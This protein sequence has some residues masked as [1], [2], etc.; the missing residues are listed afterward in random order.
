MPKVTIISP[1]YN[2]APYIKGCLK[3]VFEQTFQ[4]FELLLVDDHGQD[5]SM[6]VAREYVDEQK[7]TGRVFFL[8]TAENSGAGVARNV[9]LEAAKGKFIAF[10][11]SDDEWKPDFLE[12]LVHAA[13]K[14]GDTDLT[15]CQL[16]YSNGKVYRNPVVPSGVFSSKV[17]QL[18]LL[19]FVTFSVCFLFRRDFLTDNA[20]KFPRLRNS[21]D[22]H[23]LTSCLLLA[24]S[25]ACVDKP[26]YVYC[27]RENSLS[28]GKRKGK[29]KQRLSSA[30]QLMQ[31]FAGFKKNEKYRSLHL[32]QYN[33]VMAILFFK[34]GIAQ[35]I[36]DVL[37]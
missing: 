7:E 16:Q 27:V 24:Q 11:D 19:R 2:S 14:N 21:E 3:S 22:T 18:F 31:V 28:T 20:L 29:W 26:L 35:A 17:K 6:A 8:E 25:I 15:Y 9:G 33:C 23:F 34:K 4:D 36:R 1:V 12:Q 30:H 10:I 5:N 32:G 37:C 13:E